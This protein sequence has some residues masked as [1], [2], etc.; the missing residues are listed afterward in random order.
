M[1]RKIDI[2]KASGVLIQ[3]RKFLIVRQIGKKFFVAPGGRVEVG[4]IVIDA[5]KR[6]LKEELTIDVD[7]S[8][9]EEFGTFY[10]PAIGEE[11]KYL[12]SD[13]FLVTKWSGTIAPASEIEEIMWVNS[14]LPPDIELGSIFHHDVLPKLKELGLID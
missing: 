5:L 2:H 11:N 6:E 8:D 12:Q 14:V 4:E 3:G 10:A 9:L 1:E 13:V 7:I